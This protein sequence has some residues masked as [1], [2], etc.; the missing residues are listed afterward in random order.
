MTNLES[1]H[2]SASIKVGGQRHEERQSK[3]DSETKS[4]RQNGTKRREKR[5]G[6]KV[7][8]AR[9]RTRL[10]DGWGG[11][12]PGKRESSPSEQ[13]N[14]KQWGR[15]SGIRRENNGS[16]RDIVFKGTVA[17]AGKKGKTA[18]GRASTKQRGIKR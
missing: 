15:E 9:H 7:S 2:K 11:N 5:R 17:V 10:C 18:E 14:R 13:Q 8:D 1:S 16:K 3:G 4:E 12:P 6:K